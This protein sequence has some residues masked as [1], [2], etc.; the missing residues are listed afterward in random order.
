M[1]E[2]KVV[3][4]EQGEPEEMPE[5]GYPDDRPGSETLIRINEAMDARLAE[6]MAELEQ[7]KQ[8][9]GIL[10][11]EDSKEIDALYQPK[12]KIEVAE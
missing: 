6:L 9:A 3:L 4:P 1:S 8:T 2:S 12:P 10:F 5:E 11:D 7:P